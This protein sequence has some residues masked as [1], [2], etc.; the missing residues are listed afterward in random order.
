MKI[1]FKGSEDTPFTIAYGITFKAGETVDVTD[2]LVQKLISDGKL[3]ISTKADWVAGKLAKNPSFE[4]V[5]G[6]KP[7][8]AKALE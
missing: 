4:A 5:D 7:S 3:P 8:K 1:K 2:D 6:V